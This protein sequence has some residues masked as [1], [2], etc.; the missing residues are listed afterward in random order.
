MPTPDQICSIVENECS[1]CGTACLI[2]RRKCRACII[3]D[4][5]ELMKT[6]GLTLRKARHYVE[7]IESI[8]TTMM[9]LGD[10]LWG[11]EIFSSS[12]FVA[13]GAATSLDEASIDSHEAYQ[14]LV[15]F[16]SDDD[17]L[18]EEEEQRLWESPDSP[19]VKGT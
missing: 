1:A 18:T 15:G 16:S 7:G 2:P 11:W 6:H 13:S 12:G 14:E 9:S 8:S 5:R 17:M 3:D 10:N 4:I 19:V